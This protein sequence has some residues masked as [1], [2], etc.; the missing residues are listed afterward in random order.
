MNIFRLHDY[1]HQHLLQEIEN[2]ISRETAQWALYSD[3]VTIVPQ[4]LTALVMGLK[5]D[6]I[7]RRFVF[8]YPI[9]TSFVDFSILAVTIE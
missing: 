6:Q 2:T 3:Y 1:R 8:L 5:S 7:G 9:F 4:M